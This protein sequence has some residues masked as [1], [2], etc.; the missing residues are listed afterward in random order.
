[1]KKKCIIAVL[2]GWAA[3]MFGGIPVGYYQGADYKSASQLKEALEQIIIN[4]RTLS[5][6]D[7]W[8]YYP[9]TYYV[10]G[11]PQ[12]VLDMY[13]D[14]VTYF[15]NYTALNKEHTVPQSWWGKG[16]GFGPGCD[17]FN[18]IPSEQK[19]NSAKS[20]YPLATVNGQVTFDNGVTKVGKTTLD[21]YTG[22]AFEPKDDY[23]GD[24]ARIY[25]YVATCYPDLA[26]DANNAV[27][28]T[29]QGQTLKDW[30][31]PILLEWNAADPVDAAEIQRNEDI[32]VQQGNRNP[33]IDYPVLAE[34]IWGQKRGEEFV[35]ANH[36]A[37]EGETQDHQTLDARFDVD[38]GT[39][40]NPKN[41]AE[42]TVVNVQGGTSL[43]TLYTRVNGQEW[44][45]TACTV[46][47]NEETGAEYHTAAVMPVTISG[48]TVIEAYCTREG[49]LPSNVVTAYYCGVDFDDDFLLHEDFDAVTQGNNTSTSGSSAKWEGN[50]N[51]PVAESIF[52]AGNAVKMGSSKATGKL[53]SRTLPTA[54]GRVKVDLDV[55]GWTTV[56]GKLEVSLTGAEPEVVTYTATMSDDFEH[57]S[58]SFD[59]VEANAVLTIAT[60]AKRCFVDN[61]YVTQD[62]EAAVEQICTTD[63]T[64]LPIYNF[65]G[66][67]VDN[68]YQG[69]VIV[70]GHKYYRK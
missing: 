52:C 58:L 31:V 12:Q 36:N 48:E 47:I 53:V 70:N 33:F 68:D 64:A 29:N 32:Y 27:A 35:F 14:D 59:D 15:S 60:T 42:G 30:I 23:K 63:S 10:I 6:S 44:V 66:Q 40:G 13:S 34:Y 65:Q 17:I 67:R 41:V 38:F 11:N 51:F 46:G 49:Y 20:N 37:N 7:L 8:E 5:Y 45:E 39:A 69:I 26:W 56:E 61:V 25:F 43:S 21:G 22:S 50:V 9:Y 1:M 28:M 55:K 4:H 18:V 62:E 24:F 2:L 19:A 54:G 57:V 16:T 3:Q